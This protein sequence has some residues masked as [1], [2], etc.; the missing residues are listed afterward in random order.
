MQKIFFCFIIFLLSLLSQSIDVLFLGN[1][2]TY[3]N[4]TPLS[5]LKEHDL[6]KKKIVYVINHYQIPTAIKGGLHHFITDY[7]ADID[8][9]IFSVK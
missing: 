1:S 2:Y 3:A 6:I 9:L 8:S 7:N 4:N 5:F